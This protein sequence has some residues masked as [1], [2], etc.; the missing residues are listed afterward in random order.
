MVE[1]AR[2]RTLAS[3]HRRR[4]LSIHTRKLNIV[5]ALP[6]GVGLDRKIYY[7]HS[8]YNL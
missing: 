7:N 6:A 8:M 3:Y 1:T 2:P 5:T 4:R